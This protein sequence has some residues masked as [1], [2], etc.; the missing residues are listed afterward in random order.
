MFRTSSS[1]SSSFLKFIAMEK[2]ISKILNIISIPIFVLSWYADYFTKN[3]RVF[4]KFKHSK[5]S[6]TDKKCR[7]GLGLELKM[8]WSYIWIFDWATTS[9]KL[10]LL[11]F[12]VAL[13]SFFVYYKS[14][15]TLPTSPPIHSPSNYSFM[16]SL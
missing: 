6:G 5:V 1:N 2:E 9:K 15:L 10:F 12:K 7:I 4:W 3:K 8:V 11:F 13:K 14:T 16:E